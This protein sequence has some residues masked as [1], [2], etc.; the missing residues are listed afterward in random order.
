MRRSPGRGPDRPRRREP[1]RDGVRAAAIPLAWIALLAGFPGS[2]AAAPRQVKVVIEFRQQ[3]RT[4][5]QGVQGSGA[6]SV[7]QRSTRAG[8]GVAAEDTVTITTR[9]SGIFVVVQD[10]GSGTMLVAQEVLSP[11]RAYF[12]DYAAGKGYAVQGVTWQRLGTGL[13]VRPTVLSGGQIRLAV[14]PWLSYLTPAGGG[15]IELVEA[16]TELVVR[17]GEKVQL[18]G[19]AT[20]LHAVTRQILGYREAQ[21]AGETSVFLTATLQ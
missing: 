1:V 4:G 3:E 6:D 7:R 18:G 10:G 17:V 11:Q 12:F 14:T 21:R 8:G 16:T 5:Q 2:G 19:A 9:S 15:S 13:T 20:E